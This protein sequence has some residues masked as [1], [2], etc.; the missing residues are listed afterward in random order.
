MHVVLVVPGGFDRGGR[1]RVIPALLWL[2]EGLAERHR[3]TVVA[4]GQDATA[5]RFELAGAVVR[6][7]PAEARGPHRLARMVA[8]GIRAAGAEGPPDVV[9]GLWASVSGLVAVLAA[10]RH[11]VPSLVHV[12]GGELV[13]FPDIAY[14]GALGRGGRLIG[15]AALRG[16]DRVTVA[17]DWMADHVRAAGHR[18]DA[19][20]P[21][22]VDTARFRPAAGAEGAPPGSAALVHVGSLNGVKDQATLLRAFARVRAAR[23]DATLDVVGVD[24]LGG[25]HA[26]LAALL[27]VA[28][29][30]RFAGFVPSDELPDRLRAARLH[31]LSSRHDAGP[32][33]VLEAAACGLPTVGTAVGHV[34]DLA[35][36]TPPGAVA[37]PVGDAA[38]LADAVLAL[39]D[40]PARHVR[41][42]SAARTFALAH[43][44][45][46]T[47][48]RFDALYTEL[49]ARA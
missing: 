23:P 6:T 5:D 39:L 31:V 41:L 28:D 12:A 17:T 44:R 40:D 36:A 48:A 32:V 22:G 21:L 45:A 19:V 24:T 4:L 7:V 16:A 11:R 37:V 15:R 9:H 42:A 10:R 25:A 3:V 14:G 8:C 35:A 43:D 46:D 38:G 20:V 33:A 1:E 27:G 2:A 29:A 49:R 13:A 47:V 18:V 34:A 30:V 26:R